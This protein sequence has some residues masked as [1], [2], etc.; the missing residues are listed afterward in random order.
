MSTKAWSRLAL[1]CTCHA[2]VG[3][4]PL[5][6]AVMGALCSFNPHLKRHRS[7]SG[8]AFDASMVTFRNE[9][10]DKVSAARAQ[11]GDLVPCPACSSRH[12]PSEP[13]PSATTR[14]HS[15]CVGRSTGFSLAAA[16][17]HPSKDGR[18][19]RPWTAADGVW[20]HTMTPNNPRKHP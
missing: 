20:A 19:A 5:S 1:L 8:V 4:L 13:H 7:A 9:M 14:H 3:A 10:T 6:S 15:R 17:R 12:T 2:G 18:A 11:Q 16:H